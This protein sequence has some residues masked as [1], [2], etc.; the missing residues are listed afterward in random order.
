MK[1]FENRD[2]L[3]TRHARPIRILSEYMHPLHVFKENKVTDMVVFFG[4]ARI[5]SSEASGSE[6]HESKGKSSPDPSLYPYYEQARKL[7]ESVTLWSQQKAQAH[8]RNF[9]VCTGGGGGIMEASNRGASDAGG[10]SI[11]LGIELPME[12]GNNPYITPELNLEFHYFFT[13]KYWFMYFA[14]VLIV[15]PGGFG[16]MDELFETLT[17]QQTKHLDRQ[18]PVVLFGREFWERLIDFEYLAEL[19]LISPGDL[20]LFNKV[21]SVGEAEDFLFPYLESLL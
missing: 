6:S 5:P 19:G 3:H 1:A 20:K 12:K 9:L 18:I 10:N 4:S 15:F 13:R 8:G 21:D 14:R 16:T 2:Y 11:G 17:L 7:A